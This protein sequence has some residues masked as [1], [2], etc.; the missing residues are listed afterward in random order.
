MVQLLWK[1]IWHH[2]AELKRCI[3]FNSVIPFLD[4]LENVLRS[5]VCNTKKKWTHPR[6]LANRKMEKLIVVESHMN[7][8]IAVKISELQIR[9]LKCSNLGSIMLSKKKKPV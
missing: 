8:K 7:F 4:T 2:L 9:V 5:T 1:R 3:P 6:F